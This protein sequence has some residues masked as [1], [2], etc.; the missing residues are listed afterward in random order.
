YFIFILLFQI[1]DRNNGNILLLNTGHVVH[2][3]FGFI[4]DISPGKDITMERA[5]FKLTHGMVEVMG[6]RQSQYF[7]LYT[8]LCVK[9]FLALRD[10]AD[11][12]LH[13][14]ELMTHSGLPCFK[15][16]SMQCLRERFR[17][18]KNIREASRYMENKILQSYNNKYT[19]IYDF[20]Q[21]KLNGIEY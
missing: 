2:I 4:F 10:H 11:H 1:K 8:H 17:L 21:K 6:G 14:V 16:L 3:D 15:S 19:R 13:M 5:P 20:F 12:I 9:G 18:G 7:R